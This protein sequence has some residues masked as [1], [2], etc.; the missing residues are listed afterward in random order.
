LN[1]AKAEHLPKR[2]V[3]GFY[4]HASKSSAY[5]VRKLS[6]KE[7]FVMNPN[8]E[9]SL[10]ATGYLLARVTTALGAIPLK[11]ATVTIRNEKASN[12]G[13][14]GGV[15]KVV[16]TDLDG[17]TPRIALPAPPRANSTSPGASLPFA[18]YSV[19]V[20]AQGYYRQFFTGVPVYEGITSI[21]PANLVPFAQNASPDR[22][23]TDDTYFNEN[24]N[25]LLRP[26]PPEN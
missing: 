3:L 5:A 19:D 20:E 1:I 12:N 18:S 2:Q 13:E 7:V 22:R 4:R 8:D 17:N 21:Q 23:P 14:R 24:V 11:D 26:A 6:M 10:G 9:N 15:I 16:T 25:P